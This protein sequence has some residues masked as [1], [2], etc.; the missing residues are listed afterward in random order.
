VQLLAPGPTSISTHNETKGQKV[1]NVAFPDEAAAIPAGS[2]EFS[3]I[4][5]A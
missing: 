2:V 3:G 4:V 1:Y 5:K